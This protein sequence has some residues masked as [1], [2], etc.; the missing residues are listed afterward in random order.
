[1]TRPASA[2]T[3]TTSRLHRHRPGRQL[4]P[5]H[6]HQRRARGALGKLATTMAKAVVM[7]DSHDNHVRAAQILDAALEH[8]KDIATA[9]EVLEALAYRAELALRAEDRTPPA[10]P[11]PGPARSPSPTPNA[12]SLAGNPG[13]PRRSRG[14]GGLS[15]PALLHA[16][17][18]S[19]ASTGLVT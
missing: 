6:L 7:G 11:W 14:P 2:G 15:T 8:D 18:G 5:D 1:M 16:G 10:T 17:D 4:D 9:A 19:S 13:R 12:A 3:P